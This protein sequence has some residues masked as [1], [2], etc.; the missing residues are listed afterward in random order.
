MSYKR[1]LNDY[2]I[3]H[4][5]NR[6][7]DKNAIFNCPEDK[8]VF[9]RQLSE[10]QKEHHFN[11]YAYSLMNTHFHFLYKDVGKQM[12]TIIGVLQENY[13]KYYNAKYNHTGQV[14]ENP[15]KSKPVYNIKYFFDLVC[16]IENNPVDANIVQ[17]YIDYI[18]NSQ[19]NG[20]SYLNMIDT[21]FL[22]YYFTKYKEGTL[23]KFIRDNHTKNRKCDFEFEQL[24]DSDAT[25]CFYNIIHSLPSDE[26]YNFNKIDNL[27]KKDIVQKAYYAG[28]SIRQI[29][30]ISGISIRFIRENKGERDYL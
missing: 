20:Y 22:N 7:N 1:I 15:F 19:I 12:P 29:A 11:L 18:W 5:Y 8:E 14:F 16:Y 17:T 30:N 28:L 9:L 25:S 6:G 10:S 26:L 23:N 2:G 4:I 27:M 24:S 3:Y 21:E 13:A